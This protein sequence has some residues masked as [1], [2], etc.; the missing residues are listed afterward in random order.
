MNE[1]GF[2]LIE[3]IVGIMLIGIAAG[4]LISSGFQW[5]H[6][7][8][9][10][11]TITDNYAVVQAIEIINADYRYRFSN[12]TNP[13]LSYLSDPYSNVT[14]L[15]SEVNVSAAEITFEEESSQNTK[16]ASSNTTLSADPQ[17]VLVTAQKNNSR[18]V[19]LLGK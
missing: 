17:Y 8:T 6:A 16:I 13:T 12:N 11:N 3:I 19:I 4:L 14:G 2:T 9:P 5:T 15:S 1:K 10:L 18:M 7:S